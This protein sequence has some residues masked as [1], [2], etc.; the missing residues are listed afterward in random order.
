MTGRGGSTHQL[1]GVG[2]YASWIVYIIMRI[3]IK[4]SKELPDDPEY[5]SPVM[6]RRPK[7]Y[8]RIATTCLAPELHPEYTYIRVATVHSRG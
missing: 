7:K 8:E 4:S 3:G 6:V 1:H 5:H 2:P